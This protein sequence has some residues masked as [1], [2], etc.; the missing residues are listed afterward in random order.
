MQFRDLGLNFGDAASQIES[1]KSSGDF[2]IALQIFPANLCLSRNLGYCGERPQ[3]GRPG[4]P[5]V[6]RP[7]VG[8]DDAVGL[9]GVLHVQGEARRP[10]GVARVV[11]GGQDG[12]AE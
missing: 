9:S 3:R 11:V 8:D 5:R 7:H 4:H 1:F 6:D 2:Q 10:L 12:S